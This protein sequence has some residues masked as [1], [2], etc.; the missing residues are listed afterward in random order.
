MIAGSR[1]KPASTREGQS[2]GCGPAIVDDRAAETGERPGLVVLLPEGT[3]F[4]QADEALGVRGG[5]GE[6]PVAAAADE[7]R[8]PRDD[9]GHIPDPAV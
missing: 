4:G 3:G 7:E 1:P 9:W 5:E 8:G 6:Q 2:A